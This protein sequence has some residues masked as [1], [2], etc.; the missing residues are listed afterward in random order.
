MTTA[1]YRHF[2][3]DGALLYVGISSNHLR[4]LLQHESGAAWAKEIASVT[5]EHHA[6]RALAIAAERAAIASEN[7]R[8]NSPPRWTAY[9]QRRAYVEPVWSVW[10]AG[11][12]RAAG[13]FDRESAY[14]LHARFTG[15][16]ELGPDDLRVSA[17]DPAEAEE[18][19]P[20]TALSEEWLD[21]RFGKV[22]HVIGAR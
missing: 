6:T 1:L 13:W 7:P 22:V 3:A 11:S 17:V 16:Y 21:S 14:R 10:H 18:I 12:G 8:H 20:E 4:R 19:P 2:A 9:G 5:V 15:L